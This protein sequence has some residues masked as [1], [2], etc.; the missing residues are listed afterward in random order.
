MTILE[1][2]KF[3]NTK[4]FFFHLLKSVNNKHTLLELMSRRNVH[5]HPPRERLHPG[6]ETWLSIVER[7]SASSKM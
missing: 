4:N 3:Q 6:G 2:K 5:H 7:T 1:T